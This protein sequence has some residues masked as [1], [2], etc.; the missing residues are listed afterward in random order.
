MLKLSF[1]FG[2]IM[3]F[4]FSFAQP[5]DVVVDGKGKEHTIKFSSAVQYDEK[6]PAYIAAM[7]L[8]DTG[9]IIF[10]FSLFGC[11][12]IKNFNRAQFN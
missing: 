6:H 8:K 4:G 9:S 10:V 1:L 2:F 5:P 11:S 3:L 7:K 12:D